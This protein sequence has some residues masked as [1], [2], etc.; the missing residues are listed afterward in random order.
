MTLIRIKRLTFVL[1][2]G[3]LLF[4][5]FNN[6]E[7]HLPETDTSLPS[8][9]NTEC[10]MADPS[11]RSPTT[12]DGVVALIN[13]LPKPLTLPCFLENL[14][15]PM[16]VNSTRSTASAQP[17]D[18]DSNPRVFIIMGTK[19]ILSVVPT[20]P[21]RLLLE[22]SEYVNTQD[23]VKAEI[24]FPVTATI[25]NDALYD[26][27]RFTS[28][29]SCGLCHTRERSASI[30][31][32]THPNAFVSEVMRPTA[33]MISSNSGRSYALACNTATELYRCQMLWAVFVNGKAQDSA[34]P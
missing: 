24:R 10:A 23:S 12:F 2:V 25:G 7:P 28:G 9:M 6:C 21:G 30:Y 26:H 18:S 20:G 11:L 5:G 13:A 14:P 4:G 29:T 31:G 33:R 34:M 17:S 22:M 15:K 32:F 27:I 8:Q 1:A 19:L 3:A 16:K